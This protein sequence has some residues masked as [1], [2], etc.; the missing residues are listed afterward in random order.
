MPWLIFDIFGTKDTELE[1]ELDR[2]SVLRHPGIY[3]P[4]W[5]LHIEQSRNLTISRQAILYRRNIMMTLV[6]PIN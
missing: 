5:E 4:F 1:S 2:S 3:N 6:N